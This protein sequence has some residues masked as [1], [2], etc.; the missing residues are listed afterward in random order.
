MTVAFHKKAGMAEVYV[1]TDN[2][3][4]EPFRINNKLVFPEGT[5]FDFIH[6]G[7]QFLAVKEPDESK[8]G[9]VSHAREELDDAFDVHRE[10]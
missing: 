5:Q 7:E 9:A 8:R 6:E 4:R 2:P 10:K 3:N 1:D